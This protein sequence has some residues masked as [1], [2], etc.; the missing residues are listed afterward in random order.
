MEWYLDFSAAI[1]PLDISV[2]EAIS[3]FTHSGLEAEQLLQLFFRILVGCCTLNI[4]FSCLKFLLLGL[5]IIQLVIELLNEPTLTHYHLFVGSQDVP[6]LGYS[7]TYSHLF[8]RRVI[9]VHCTIITSY[10]FHHRG[11]YVNTLRFFSSRTRKLSVISLS[12]HSFTITTLY[13]ISYIFGSL[14][15]SCSNLSNSHTFMSFISLTMP[16]FILSRRNVIIYSIVDS[17][18]Y[19]NSFWFGCSGKLGIAVLPSSIFF[20]LTYCLLSSSI[21]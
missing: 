2:D 6:E 16:P 5:Q 4:S 7:H 3:Q 11:T 18:S 20:L 15:S 12:M 21:S 8:W 19:F 1:D 10:R 9:L 17:V 13:S 14:F